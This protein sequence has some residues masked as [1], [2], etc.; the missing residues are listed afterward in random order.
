M[1]E[2][3]DGHASNFTLFFVWCSLNFWMAKII[4]GDVGPNFSTA[5]WAVVSFCLAHVHAPC[6]I[7]HV[8]GFFFF[9]WCCDLLWCVN[10][11]KKNKKIKNGKQFDQKP[12]PVHKPLQRVSYSFFFYRFMFLILSLVCLKTQLFFKKLFSLFLLLFISLIIIFGTVCESHCIIL[13]IFYLY[14]W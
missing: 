10:E 12:V 11:E 5:L 9:W 3:K 4:V 1:K 6:T 7:L 8:F 14:L 2:G 13:I